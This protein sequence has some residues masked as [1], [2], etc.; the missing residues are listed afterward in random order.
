M[1]DSEGLNN[2][3]WY[4]WLLPYATNPAVIALEKAVK[5]RSLVSTIGRV[6][7]SF[8]VTKGNGRGFRLTA[9]SSGV[10]HYLWSLA[11]AWSRLRNLGP[12]QR[13]YVSLGLRRPSCWTAVPLLM[14]GVSPWVTPHRYYR[15]DSRKPSFKT[16]G[17]KPF[18]KKF[19][20]RSSR[21]IWLCID[22]ICCRSI[23]KQ[24]NIFIDNVAILLSRMS[25]SVCF[26]TKTICW[27]PDGSSSSVNTPRKI[28]CE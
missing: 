20:T 27:T 11:A 24:Y 19:V 25:R 22:N 1:F 13:S 2:V 23:V 14:P 9:S 15:R 26:D 21:S 8:D 16:V 6:A 7:N 3:Y 18:G 4:Y 12:G 5:N 17:Q 10:W 28:P